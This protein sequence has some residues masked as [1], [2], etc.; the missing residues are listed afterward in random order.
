MNGSGSGNRIIDS[1]RSTV[2][3]LKRDIEH[4]GRGELNQISPETKK[5]IVRTV[6][7]LITGARSIE[8]S[9]D[10][11]TTVGARRE[12]DGTVRIGIRI[13]L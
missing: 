11:R 5:Q 4:L 2:D 1:A 3:R 13:E 7:D 9:L 12:R 10:E 8:I 6:S